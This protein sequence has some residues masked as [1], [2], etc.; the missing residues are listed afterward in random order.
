MQRGSDVARLGL[1]AACALAYRNRSIPI[2]IWSS[3]SDRRKPPRGVACSQPI[4]LPLS[5]RQGKPYSFFVPDAR[6]SERT[7]GGDALS[8]TA[9]HL[10]SLLSC[11]D[12][13]VAGDNRELN[14]PDIDC[15]RGKRRAVGG[16]EKTGQ[17]A[18]AAHEF[19]RHKGGV[20]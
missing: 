5:E 10:G 1:R 6:S 4:F 3:L 12:V 16:L 15:A 19:K 2:M 14:D 18:G 11:E 9:V 17:A 20:S 8:S 13:V 7:S